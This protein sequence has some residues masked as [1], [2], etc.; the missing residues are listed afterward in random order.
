VNKRKGGKGGV[1]VRIERRE[2][3]TR[4]SASKRGGGNKGR[5]NEGFE[6]ENVARIIAGRVRPGVVEGRRG[7]IPPEE[8]RGQPGRQRLTDSRAAVGGLKR[9]IEKV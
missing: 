4:E 2:S 7:S 1:D 8:G 6:V 3:S 5:A 9:G